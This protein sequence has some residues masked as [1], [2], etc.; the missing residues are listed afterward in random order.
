MLSNMRKSLRT[1]QNLRI[2]LI[3]SLSLSLLGAASCQTAPPKWDG[4]IWAGDSATGS[5]QRAQAGEAIACHEVA[6]N[7]YLCISGADFQKFYETYVFGCKEWKKDVELMSAKEAFA[8]L[9]E[10]QGLGLNVSPTENR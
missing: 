7:G 3:P 8:M 4:K 1:L 9:R 6:F 5:I 10:L 2:F